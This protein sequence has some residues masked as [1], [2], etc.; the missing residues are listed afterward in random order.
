MKKLIL[1]SLFSLSA[2]Q[3]NSF[4]Q[5]APTSPSQNQLST[6]STSDLTGDFQIQARRLRRAKASP[7]PKPTRTPKPTATP[8]PSPTPSP[9][10]SPKPSSVPS[11][12]PSPSPTASINPSPTPSA[13][14]SNLNTII[15]EIQRLTNL[16]RSKTGAAALSI[17]SLLNQAAQA[18][19][20]NMAQ[21]G[22]F[23][24]V[25]NNIG[26]G[27]RITAT[28]YV[29]QTYGENIAYG[30]TSPE[31]VMSGWMNSDGHRANILNA[32]FTE[33]GVGYATNSTGRPYW[34]QV[35]AKPR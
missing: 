5:I 31:S 8:K 7:T 24:H 10:S 29:W 33:L 26:P 22:Q 21:T 14:S 18:H 12:T 17:N 11:S 4:T 32:N 25:I 35:F 2:C 13:P 9:S 20:V 1:L 15:N 27:E 3:I 34:V 6:Q 16:E 19:A 28:G 23:S 30:Y